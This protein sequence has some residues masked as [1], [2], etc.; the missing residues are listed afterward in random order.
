MFIIL[1][2]KIVFIFILYTFVCLLVNWFV[3]RRLHLGVSQLISY[4]VGHQTFYVLYINI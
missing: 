3:L 1:C 4:F 2:T